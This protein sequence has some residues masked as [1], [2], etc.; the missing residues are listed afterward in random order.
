MEGQRVDAD[1]HVSDSY[2]VNPHGHR[3]CAEGGEAQRVLGCSEERANASHVAEASAQHV[4][5]SQR[6]GSNRVFPI[7]HVRGAATAVAAVI[8]AS[9]AANR[10]ASVAAVPALNVTKPVAETTP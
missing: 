3:L 10:A 4:H 8:A 5:A 2:I 1:R 6:D 9:V 7:S